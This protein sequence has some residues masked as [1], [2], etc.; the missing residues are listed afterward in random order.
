MGASEVRFRSAERRLWD[1]VGV[2][3]VERRVRLPRTNCVVRVQEVG[4][5]P[6]VVFV[7][8]GSN[9]GSSW[10][11]LVVRLDGLRCIMLDRPGCGLSDPLSSP[12]DGIDGIEAFADVLI[13]D[14]LDAL[15]LTSAHVVATSYGGYFAF[16]A[17]AA[18]PERIDR[19]VEFSWSVGAPMAKVP[20]L[21][22]LGGTPGLGW[23]MARVPPTERSVRMM[24]RQIGL[25]AALESGRFTPE[26]LDWYIALLRHTHTMRNDIASSP[27]LVSPIHGMNEHVLLPPSL[28]AAIR[29]PTYFL[30]GADDPN[31]G[32]DIARAFVD[33]LPNARLEMLVGAGHAPWMD[34]PDHTAAATRAWL[35]R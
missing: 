14:V 16:R 28:L 34:D 19:M 23:L 1:S 35:E 33:L 18:A 4:D 25:G 13:P 31:G 27:K 3:P 11:S 29:A 2:E 12:P 26:A 8:G 5:G 6:P 22:R 7:H 24:L 21:M 20:P 30:W 32:A 15:E 10:A 9:G 17:A